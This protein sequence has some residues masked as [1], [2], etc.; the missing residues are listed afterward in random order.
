MYIRASFIAN[1]KSPKLMKPGY[2]SL[3][4]PAMNPQ[5]AAM[6]L[7]PSRQNRFYSS[8]A[9]LPAMRFGMIRAISLNPVRSI[10]G[11]PPFPPQGRNPIHKRYQLGDIMSVRFCQTTIQ[12]YSTRIGNEMML[13]SGS[14]SI[15]GIRPA[16]F[17][18]PPQRAPKRNP[19]SP[20]SSQSLRPDEAVP[21]G[22]RIFF[23]RCLLH[24]IH[25]G[26]SSRSFRNRTP[27]RGEA[28]PTGFLFSG[29]RGCPS[30]RADHRAVFDQDGH[31]DAVWRE[32]TGAG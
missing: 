17:P 5:S 23:S 26:D 9:Q 14:S 18:P 15:R 11:T 13:A 8:I 16:F 20:A 4:N 21:A 29:R 30:G 6:L 27:S 25:A 31:K 28:F 12:G 22:Q 1:T 7:I 32:A 10:S 3:N 24:A 19:Q 2:G